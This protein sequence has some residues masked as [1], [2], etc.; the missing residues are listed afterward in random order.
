M[1]AERVVYIKAEQAVLVNKREVRLEDV[2][3]MTGSDTK[4]VRELGKQIL[5]QVPE[6]KKGKYT[7][8]VLKLIEL[9]GK[10]YPDYLVMNEG[11]S[12]LIVEY[13]PPG[14]KAMWVEYV[15]IMFVC[16]TVLVGSAF[17]IMTFNQ[18]V[19]VSDIFGKLHRIL[20]GREVTGPGMLEIGYCIGLPAGIILF[21]NHF[22][23][24]KMSTDPT[25]LQVQLRIYE[26]D[27]NDAILQT[28][29]REGKTIDV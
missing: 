6:E 17:T 20:Y 23:K 5:F 11:A 26:T 24:A 8:S 7:F 10:K 19:S 16:L 15:K 9:I 22:S 13:A 3:K 18:D 2:L 27:V 1:A 28:A 12:D 4:A 29:S 21:F 14:K 25:P